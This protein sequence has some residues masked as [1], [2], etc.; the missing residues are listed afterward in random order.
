LVLKTP[1]DKIEIEVEQYFAAL[2]SRTFEQGL[3][4]PGFATHDWTNDFSPH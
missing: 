1:L 4:F 3:P 2:Y